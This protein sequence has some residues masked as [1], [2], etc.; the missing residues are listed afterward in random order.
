[1]RFWYVFGLESA[2]N[3]EKL[4]FF[5]TGGLLLM[6]AAVGILNP[7]ILNNTLN[8]AFSWVLTYFGWW[9]MLLGLILL[10]FSTFM[11]FSRYGRIRIGGQDA[12]PEFSM[13]RGSRWY[14]RSDTA[15]RSSYGESANLSLL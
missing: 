3:G 9:F 2:D 5:I 7:Q 8:G 11:V 1:M 6:L 13:F 10:V 14:S 12:E 4:L 15:D